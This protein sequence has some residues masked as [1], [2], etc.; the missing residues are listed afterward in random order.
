[1]PVLGVRVFSSD[2]VTVKVRG[3][4]SAWCKTGLR[5]QARLPP[6]AYQYLN[7][8]RSHQRQICRHSPDRAS[9][10]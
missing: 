3:A 4:F 2:D 8:V 1:M 10:R 5:N 6:Q 7:S 9:L